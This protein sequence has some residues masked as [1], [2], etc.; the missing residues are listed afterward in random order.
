M[1]RHPT[2][3]RD[4]VL[5]T[6]TEKYVQ[7][8]IPSEWL[9]EKEKHDYGI[10]LRVEITI[11]SNT[12]KHGKEE[13]ASQVTGVY[14]SIQLKGTDKLFVNKERTHVSHKCKVSALNYYL[15]RP[16]PIIYLVYDAKADIAYWV[17]IQDYIRGQKDNS[18][19]NQESLTINIPIKNVFD[20]RSIEE[21]K[22]ATLT[23]HKQMQW[24]VATQTASNPYYRYS[25]YKDE[26]SISIT[27][28]PRYSGA[29]K[30]NP[31]IFK[32]LLKFDDSLEAQKTLDSFRE[33]VRTGSSVFI[34]EQ[35]IEGFDFT[36]VFPDLFAHID[37]FK[38]Q[39]I[40]ILPVKS[41][42]SFSV[43]MTFFDKNKQRV[44]EI[45]FLEFWQIQAGTEEIT[46][47]NE[48]QRLPLRVTLRH[49]LAEKSL[50][51]GL[52]AQFKGRIIT[53]IRDFL[54]LQQGVVKA[55]EVKITNIV[56][57]VTVYSE[58]SEMSLITLP[59]DPELVNFVED[60]AI[61]QDELRQSIVWNE[62][63]TNRDI[64]KVAQ[65]KEA[66]STGVINEK[67]RGMIIPMKYENA[68][69]WADIIRNIDEN[70]QLLL[71][72]DN[73]IVTVMGVDLD[74]G[75]FRAHL[76]NVKFN[77]ETIMFLSGIDKSSEDGDVN[78][79][80][81]ILDPGVNYIVYRWKKRLDID[82]E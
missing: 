9:F 34:G 78:I 10:D 60:L 11:P 61:I 66:I 3:T 76:P 32:G 72:G 41:D 65:L 17:F 51:I 12:V 52:E 43:M 70:F 6:E 28:H 62:V 7:R 75:R 16:E 13:V 46:Y 48:R 59:L 67:R 5:E 21:I 73:L 81:D 57:G 56:T 29:E 26:K 47:S 71:E 22:I 77:Q 69:V 35:F 58:L 19:K 8:F 55:H 44:A 54:H 42:D 50:T 33:S 38:V 49:N 63:V 74:L 36:E 45:P 4:H 1:P 53:Q 25:F 39:S 80:I 82:V 40:E 27:V 24:L 31:L 2:R 15:S 23:R 79:V 37:S 68:Q 14:F 64:E 30:D 18:W 20:K